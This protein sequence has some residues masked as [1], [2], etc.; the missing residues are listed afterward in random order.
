[1]AL[2]DP[3][4]AP[5][6]RYPR[7]R[8]LNQGKEIGGVAQITVVNN[9][10]YVA[11]TFTAEFAINEVPGFGTGY[12][13]SRDAPFLVDLQASLDAGRTW[14]SLLTGQADHIT[15]TPE[16]G[17]CVVEGR[18]LTS[19]FI[20]TKT[21][22]S[23][24]N[25][26]ASQVVEELAA[27]HGMTADVTPTKTLVQRYYSDDHDKLSNGDFTRVTTE[28]NLIVNLAQHEQFEVWVTGNTIHF[29]PLSQRDQNPYEVVWQSNPVSS[30]AVKLALER[31]MYMAKD[32]VVAV[33]SWH[34]KNGRGFTKFSPS[35]SRA[36]GTLAGKEQ[37]FTYT[38][39]NLTESQALDLAN[40]FR[41]ELT[42]H[43]RL[44]S[45]SSPG[46][47]TLTARNMLLVSGT[48]SSWDQTYFIDTVT[49]RI[50]W[51][52]FVMSVKAKN[53]SPESTVLP[54]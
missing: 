17:Q 3:N 15:V 10:Y 4:A 18:D 38:I 8:I 5:E 29:H 50:G 14:T 43:E 28:W 52:G 6:A 19:Y 23:Y 2:N 30:N 34:S 32:I 42:K 54:R 37:Q 22:H 13:G 7:I 47:L 49:R 25:K 45:F 24:L 1:M 51:N 46:D 39:P 36:A 27:K 16:N 12:W 53:H 21:Q 11:D 44:I 26:T 31:S 35:G 41:E 9:A 33:R 48:A 40:K 20:D